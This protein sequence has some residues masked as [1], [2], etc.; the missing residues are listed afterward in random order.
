MVADLKNDDVQVKKI[1]PFI[2]LEHKHQL[3]FFGGTSLWVLGIVRAH[4]RGYQDSWVLEDVFWPII[5]LIIAYLWIVWREDDNRWVALFSSWTAGIVGIV[6]ALKYT[7]P[8]G[9]TIDATTH[10][11][12]IEN[13]F[14]TGRALDGHVYASINALHASL[15]SLALLAN[16]TPA[17]VVKYGMAFLGVLPPLLIYLIVN[18]VGIQRNVAKYIICSSVLVIYPQ[19]APNGTAFSLIP[20][21]VILG[22]L[23]LR[24]YYTD[25]SQQKRFFTFVIS[26][27]LV[28]LVIWHSTTP[29]ILPVILASVALTPAAANLI[30]RRKFRVQ[31]NLTGLLLMTVS[32]LLFLGYHF[33]VADRVGQIMVQNVRAQ[34]FDEA[35]PAA[36]DLEEE[37]ESL[38]ED[39]EKII[40]RISAPEYIRSGIV[41]HGRDM[42]MFG[43]MFV[44]FILFIFYRERFQAQIHFFTYLILVILPFGLFIVAN[45]GAGYLRFLKAPLF[46]SPF[47]AGLTFW[48]VFEIILPKIQA[49]MWFRLPAAAV[50]IALVLSFWMVQQFWYQPLVPKIDAASEEFKDEYTIWTH[51]V[52]T[53]YQERMLTFA[54]TRA[55]ENSRFAIDL[56]GRHQYLRYFGENSG[57]Q[58]GLYL[59]LKRSIEVTP[60]LIQY[61]LLHMPGDAGGLGENITKR[62]DEYLRSLQETPYWNQVYDNGESFILQ[63]ATIPDLPPEGTR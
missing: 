59:P 51:E 41:L 33:S 43:L 4:R 37:P 25:S 18:R 15:A 35:N 26:L 48:W 7:Q 14:E 31:V 52:N 8:Y 53:T 5:I 11:L 62:S 21:F 19:F 30:R 28:Q 38:E 57:R 60:D 44:G 40:Y 61:F 23:L 46:I 22:L 56:R 27:T 13:L 54:E 36:Q 1:T 24:E 32:A 17:Q 34:F 10:Y 16:A 63:I 20:L 50:I 2:R 45:S 9:T 49:G 47:F 29:L 6:P 55:A 39:A 12:L 42:M 58:R 3:L